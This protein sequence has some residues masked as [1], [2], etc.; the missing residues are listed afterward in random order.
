MPPAASESWLF[1]RAGCSHMACLEF[2]MFDKTCHSFGSSGKAF[3]ARCEIYQTV[4]EAVAGTGCL[5]ERSLR[6]EASTEA[7][8]S[9]NLPAGE[10]IFHSV[11]CARLMSGRLWFHRGVLYVCKSFLM[12]DRPNEERITVPYGSVLGQKLEGSSSWLVA[13]PEQSVTLVLKTN[14]PA[15]GTLV[16]GH[17][18][19]EAASLCMTAIATQVA[20]INE[21]MN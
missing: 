17:M 11:E 15:T 10:E 4:S 20:N 1:S 5:L 9:L 21:Y 3:P 6:G 14:R 2:T 8:S 16:F 12:F 19:K 18:S 7:A 13:G